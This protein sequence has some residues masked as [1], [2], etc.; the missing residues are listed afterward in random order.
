MIYTIKKGK[1]YPTLPIPILTTKTWVSFDFK[2][3]GTFPYSIGKD[4]SD[5]NKLFGI[6][7][8][9]NIHA[10]TV[11]LGWRNLGDSNVIELFIYVHNAYKNPNIGNR[12]IWFEKIGECLPNQLNHCLIGIDK[13]QKQYYTIFNGER[14]NLN[15][16]KKS[17]GWFR[18]F[19]LPYWGGDTKAPHE[20]KIEINRNAQFH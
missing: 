12:N 5:I 20:Y 10:N 13:K 1:N 16:S 8:S 3:T 14:T 6:A 19:T 2:I 17:L 11:M 7:E 15:R 18:Y 4:Q 9:W